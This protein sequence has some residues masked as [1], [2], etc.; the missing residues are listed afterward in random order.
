MKSNYK[1]IGE[2]IREVNNRNS[3]LEH[4]NLLGI[5]ID[6]FFMP[7]VAN[8]VGKRCAV[9]AQRDGCVRWR[10]LM[11]SIVFQDVRKTPGEPR[12][13]VKRRDS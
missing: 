10:S 9:K 5:N 6:K 12:D 11:R 2:C 7:S 3:N 13:G 4:R 8:V 1:S